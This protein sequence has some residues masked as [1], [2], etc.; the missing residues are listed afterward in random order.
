MSGPYHIAFLS[1]NRGQIGEAYV[2]P[3]LA[4]A[5]AARGHRVDLLR[6]WKEWEGVDLGVQNNP[7][8]VV[9]LGTRR[10]LPV[11]PSVSRISSWANYRI[12]GALMA[13]AMMPGFVRYLRRERPDFLVARMQ[14]MASIIAKGLSRNDTKLVL[15][16]AGM[17]RSSGYRNFLWPRL[18]PRAD[19]FVAPAES[20]AAVAAERAN[21]DS[22]R[23]DVIPNPVISE[24]VLSLSE[25]P[26]DHAWFGDPGHPLVIA[27]GR[28]T[29]QKD[30]PTLVRAMARVREKVPARLLIV[31]EGEGE[32]RGLIDG[33]TTELGLHDAVQ[34]HGFDPNPYKYMRAADLFVMSSEWEGPGHVLIEAQA[35]GTPAVS[36]DCP[37]GPRDTLLDGRAGLLVPVGDSEAMADA[38]I[39]SLTNREAAQQR[40]EVGLK[41]RDSYFPEHVAARW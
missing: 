26:V 8:R 29:R 38:I 1:P 14:T 11:L 22:D 39:E 36:T 13:G 21:M 18:Y 9:N 27:V 10:L 6:V 3:T 16:M 23:F 19:A 31:G 2:V 34:L 28:L 12:Q 37:A 35:L 41:N 33:L 7:V 17:P 20:V 25:E 5:L 24:R 32:H 4:R 15:S 30:F 40:A